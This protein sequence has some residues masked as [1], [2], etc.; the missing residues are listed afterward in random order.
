M[1]GTKQVR[2]RPFLARVKEMSDCVTR[3]GVTGEPS[4]LSGFKSVPACA[5]M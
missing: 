1:Q 5:L 4:K 3:K 2:W